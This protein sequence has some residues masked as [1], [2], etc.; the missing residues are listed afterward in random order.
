MEAEGEVVSKRIGIGTKSEHDAIV[1]K[2]PAQEY[3]LRR[4]GGNPFVD[5]EITKLVGKR[6]RAIGV[7]D[8]GQLIMSNWKELD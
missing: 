1:L 5:P 3:K 8:S 6:I 7:V 2:T 4:Q